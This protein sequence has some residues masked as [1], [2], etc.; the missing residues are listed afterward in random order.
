LP[1]LHLPW[2]LGT[3]CDDEGNFCILFERP[4]QTNS[5][6][7]NTNAHVVPNPHGKRNVG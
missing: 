2:G 4:L 5:I 6:A 7:N 3:A 1:T